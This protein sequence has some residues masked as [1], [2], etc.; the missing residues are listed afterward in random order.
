[1]RLLSVCVVAIE[2]ELDQLVGGMVAGRCEQQRGALQL[3]AR[4]RF[5]FVGR[6]E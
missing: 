2:C 3:R 5:L 6:V 1:M 4:R